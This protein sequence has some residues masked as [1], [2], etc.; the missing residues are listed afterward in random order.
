MRRGTET[1]ATGIA[2]ADTRTTG[3]G[4]TRGATGATPGMTAPLAAIAS[5]AMTVRPGSPV[6]RADRM[7]ESSDLD[8]VLALERELQ[9]P[10][11]R[12]DPARLEELLAPEY[13]EF[14]ASGQVWSRTEIIAELAGEDG[15][16]IEVHDLEAREVSDDVVLVLWRSRMADRQALRSSLWHR[17]PSGWRLVHHQGT[18]TG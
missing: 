7:P 6:T 11:C 10:A 18:P 14:G 17:E 12:S 8:L 9:T 16:V 2:V 13:I 4:A 3:A 15:G 1:G 5:S